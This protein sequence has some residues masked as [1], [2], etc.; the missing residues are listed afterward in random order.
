MLGYRA[1]FLFSFT[2]LLHFGIM[3]FYETFIVGVCSI[4]SGIFIGMI[5]S[6]FFSS[7]LLKLMLGGAPGNNIE[8]H[9]TAKSVIVTLLIFISVFIVDSIKSYRIIYRYKLIDLL[10]AEK[11][12]EKAPKFS[13]VSCVISVILIISSYCIFLSFKGDQRGLTL[14]KPGSAAC[15]ML[16]VGTYLLFHNIIIWIIY[17]LKANIDFYLKPDNLLS[18]SQL[19]YQVKSNSNILCLVCLISAFTATIMSASVSVYAALGDSMHVYSPF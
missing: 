6:R 16:A 2:K 13:K 18:T 1:I 8:F 9:L 11:K 19:G 7:I 12:A 5:C 14:I 3:M 10:H 4:I 17:K 15:I